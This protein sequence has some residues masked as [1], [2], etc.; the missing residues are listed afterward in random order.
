M[1]GGAFLLLMA[2]ELGLAMTAFDRTVAEHVRSYQSLSAIV[3][4][5]GQ[6]VFAFIPLLQRHRSGGSSGPPAMTSH[7]ARDEA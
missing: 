3:G 4:L 1:G 7:R 5:A 6:I 2:A